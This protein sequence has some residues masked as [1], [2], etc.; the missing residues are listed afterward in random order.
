MT[1]SAV[2][3]VPL[4]SVAVALGADDVAEALTLAGARVIRTGSRG[5]HWLEPLVEIEIG[6]ARHGFGG[7]EASD[8]AAIL[9]AIAS[10]KT[11][12]HPKYIGSVP[13]QPYF[14]KQKRL[15]FARCGV[16][17]PASVEDYRRHGGLRALEKALTMSAEPSARKSRRRA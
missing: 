7:A 8:A 6:G 14:K 4:D 17:D 9:N 1:D 12:S 16:V 2:L 5:M 3:Y 10:N 13:A 11:A 15:T